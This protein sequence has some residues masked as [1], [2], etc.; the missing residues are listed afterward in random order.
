MKNEVTNPVSGGIPNFI[1]HIRE[2]QYTIWP[3]NVGNH[4]VVIIIRTAPLTAEHRDA[5][6]PDKTL[7]THI[8]VVDPAKHRKT[9]DL[10]HQR[11]QLFLEYHDFVIADDS[12]TE[13]WIPKQ[14]DGWSCGIRVYHVITVMLERIKHEVL[15]KSSKRPSSIW[16]PLS[17]YFQPAKVRLELIGLLADTAAQAVGKGKYAAKVSLVPS[18]A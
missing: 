17:K 7:V 9:I 4:W 14:R 8:A 16:A 11:M 13:I 1:T 6:E 12:R 2:R 18:G 10:V 3:T 5:G 15:A